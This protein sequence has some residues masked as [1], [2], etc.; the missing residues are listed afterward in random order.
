MMATTLKLVFLSFIFASCA[1]QKNQTDNRNPHP[2]LDGDF[3]SV[4]LI[5]VGSFPNIEAATAFMVIRNGRQYFVTAR[6]FADKIQNGSVKFFGM[7]SWDND[8]PAIVTA[9]GI[10]ETDISIFVL[11][12]KIPQKSLPRSPLATDSDA[13][14]LGDEIWTLGFPLALQDSARERTYAYPLLKHGYIAGD[15]SKEQLFLDYHNNPISSGSP[16]FAKNLRGE[17]RVIGIMSSFL[18]ERIKTDST[19]YFEDNS[20]IALAVSTDQIDSLIDS[21]P[22]GASITE[23]H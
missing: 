19:A 7:E 6:H 10:G 22:I 17:S 4:F 8:Y 1:L 3:H 14:R 18:R 23:L 2:L 20:G 15:A 13:F 12:L 9:R 5:G 21:K 16:V 11:P